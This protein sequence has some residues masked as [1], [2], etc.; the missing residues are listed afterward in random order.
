MD[1]EPLVVLISP[2]G[3]VRLAGESSGG[4]TD[5]LNNQPRGPLHGLLRLLQDLLEQG[6]AQAPEGR[7]A[8]LTRQKQKA[9]A[10]A[11]PR[12]AAVPE[13]RERRREP[14]R[15]H[16]IEQELQRQAFEREIEYWFE[17]RF[18]LPRSEPDSDKERH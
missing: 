1:K 14:E 15:N 10:Y 11:M 5:N 7:I 4:M 13:L 9:N 16:E 2:C 6:A 18:G 8:W 12:P 17:A 3:N